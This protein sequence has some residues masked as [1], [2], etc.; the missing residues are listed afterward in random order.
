MAEH[1]LNGLISDQLKQVWTAAHWEK[2]LKKSDIFAHD[3]TESVKIIKTPSGVYSLKISAYLLLGLAKIYYK[4]SLLIEEQVE[5]LLEDPGIKSKYE[6]IEMLNAAGLTKTTEI[7]KF[8]PKISN[9]DLNAMLQKLPK[10]RI[11][12]KNDKSERYIEE[13][14]VVNARVKQEVDYF[15]VSYSFLKDIEVADCWATRQTET[16]YE[17]LNFPQKRR[18]E[19]PWEVL[20][21]DNIIKSQ[22]RIIENQENIIESQENFGESQEDIIENKENPVKIQEALEEASESLMFT[23]RSRERIGNIQVS[24]SPLTRKRF[25]SSEEG[26]MLDPEL[27]ASIDNTNDIVI[28]LNYY[29][30]PTKSLPINLEL[31]YYPPV[32]E[33]MA[34][35]LNNF[36]TSNMK[37]IKLKEKLLRTD[38][39]P[40]ILSN[41]PLP[42]PENQSIKK[43]ICEYQTFLDPDEDIEICP[44]KV[45]KKEEH[46]EDYSNFRTFKILRLLQNRFAQSKRNSVWFDELSKI[47]DR[48]VLSC[49]FCEILQLVI[50]EYIE[51]KNIEGRLLIKPN[52]RILESG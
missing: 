29:S 48:K 44:I 2:K 21:N 15:G 50:Q 45:I 31:M 12:K 40:T 28:N 39:E 36:Y 22:E 7:V 32:I 26:I 16:N 8:V 6:S 37:I 38:E 47:P 41:N 24:R 35:E 5:G 51:I 23:I 46:I 20:I 11:L 17:V 34:L 27:F 25:K 9:F 18:R 1:R 43:E 42:R 30:P 19:A 33:N 4:K 13:D 49:G 10:S 14:Y 3:V 52:I